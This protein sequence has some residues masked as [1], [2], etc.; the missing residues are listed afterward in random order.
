MYV[1]MYVMYVF[2]TITV[3]TQSYSCYSPRSNKADTQGQCD[4]TRRD[5]N[6]K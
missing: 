3:Y 6:D 2:M 5:I 4:L 1:C